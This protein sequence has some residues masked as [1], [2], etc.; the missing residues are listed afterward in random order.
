[1]D[2]R[3]IHISFLLVTPRGYAPENAPSLPQLPPC[4]NSGFLLNICPFSV[5]LTDTKN[6]G[7]SNL[8]CKGTARWGYNVSLVFGVVAVASEP[9]RITDP[10]RFGEDFELDLRAYELRRGG[11]PL[12]LEPI[13]MALLVLLVERKGELVTRDQI[14]ERVWG[15]DVFFDT[16]NGINSAVRKLRQALRD[17]P[18]HP[19]FVLTVIGKGYR[20]LAA[21]EEPPPSIHSADDSSPVPPP[22]I[23][24][25]MKI[26]HYRIIQ[27]LGGGG[28]GVVYKAE[29]LKL[30]RAVALKFL[31]GELASDPVAFERLQREARAA[32][33]LDHPNICSIYQ[34]DEH[35]G[36]PFIVMQLL[37]GQTLRDWIESA[38]NKNTAERVQALTD[39]GVQIADGLQAAHQK[40][41]IHRDI[42]P[43]NIFVTNRSQVKILDF[44]VAK[45]LDA[46]E[47]SHDVTGSTNAPLT[48]PRLTR[49]GLS[50]GTPSYFSPEQIK[51]EKLDSRTDIFSFGL[52]LYEMATGQQ[53]FRG[54]SEAEIYD[55][56]LNREPIWP[57]DVRGE[58]PGELGAIID[59]A[60]EKNRDRRYQHAA[61]IR[62]DLQK[63]NRNTVSASVVLP[64]RKW[65][66]PW[67][68]AGIAAA[69]VLI[70][71]SLVYFSPRRPVLPI[72][73]SQWE[74]ITDF[75]DSAVQPSLS[76]DGHMLAFIRG[77]NTFVTPG[78]VYLKFMPKGEPVPL[79]HDDWN[80]ISPVFS[81]D[82]SR[83]AY[84]AIENF[85]WNTYQVFV[86]GGEPKLLLP[87]AAGLSWLDGGRVAFGEIRNGV[88]M[89]LVTATESRDDEHDL[90]FPANEKGM[91][92]F[93]YPS[94]DKKWI[95]AAEMENFEWIRC[96]LLPADGSSTGNPIG[97]NGGCPSAA[98][99]PDG[100]WIYLTSYNGGVASHIWRVSFANRHAEQVTSGPTEEAGI[101][102]A[103][104][105]KSLITSMGTEHYTVWYH[106]DKGDHQVLSEGSAFY[107][108]LTSD[109][110]AL[111]F[112]QLKQGNHGA[113]D[114]KGGHQDDV[115]LIRTDLV[116]GVS[117]QVL[118][119]AGMEGVS[120]S[121]DGTQ[122]V[123]CAKGS[124]KRSHLWSLPANHNAPPRQLTPDAP[125]DD[126]P[127]ILNNGDVLF[128]RHE[129][130]AFFAYRTRADG[131]G[132]EKILTA[133]ISY[134]LSASP[135]G[136]WLT[137]IA[138]LPNG[139]KYVTQLYR[140]PGGTGIALCQYCGSAF[141]PDGKYVYISFGAGVFKGDSKQHGLTYIFPRKGDSYF[142]SLPPSGFQSEAEAAKMAPA[143]PQANQG[144]EFFPGPSPG[145]YALMRH[146]IQRNL[147]RVPLP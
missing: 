38:A 145:N 27:L 85:K 69:I 44:G 120:V 96:R 89:G 39:I 68:Y 146:T 9:V 58:I 36:Q 86:T 50:F 147:Y 65:K 119:A 132:T 49:T 18:E 1:M 112:L 117:Q 5:G 135:D 66:S 17:D 4:L 43:A 90:Y 60:I 104:D 53:P 121:P 97:P 54:D 62:T 129:N 79:T 40:G 127:I 52:V 46:A 26:S 22:G 71:V 103:P 25:G 75:P 93:S 77:P 72:S 125:D 88:H 12:K 92:H 101:A 6:K 2:W 118:S 57:T 106:D 134:L 126:E 144:D 29:D 33:A 130:N 111:Y 137:A 74:Q 128:R 83:I 87:N 15:K 98:W 116:T 70:A 114:Q 34:L 140:L 123:Y 23:S 31:P 51:R 11:R 59:K 47:P 95:V 61:D 99:S 124:D 78:Q 138:D 8:A 105:G 102:I 35:E 113:N 131:N 133:P 48:D 20:F 28:M 13:P 30:G 19:R 115:Q 94:P 16:D 67:L 76:T 136:L 91:A 37:E 139:P 141:S 109:G 100:K 80:K 142:Q 10:I 84:T 107:P 41:I 42:K 108:Q 7:C 122:I 63:V 110:R 81:P 14:I 56:I 45:H 32:S 24:P 73:T 82:G 143:V 64:D 55:N 21:I 3:C